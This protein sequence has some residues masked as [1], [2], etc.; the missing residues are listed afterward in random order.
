M[1]DK[2]QKAPKP[3]K[4]P[5][6]KAQ[7]SYKV[8]KEYRKLEKRDKLPGF[9][10]TI[11]I[12]VIFIGVFAGL[13]T[14]F[15]FELDFNPREHTEIDVSAP[16]KVLSA[17]MQNAFLSFFTTLKNVSSLA[18]SAVHT[19][20]SFNTLSDEPDVNVYL[21]NLKEVALTYIDTVSDPLYRLTL[22]ND[23]NK[24]LKALSNP[25]RI[26]IWEGYFIKGNF[27]KDYV[28]FRDLDKLYCDTLFPCWN[29]EDIHI[30]FVELELCHKYNG[31]LYKFCNH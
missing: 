18:D 29:A 21:L 7:E 15:D 14:Q 1:A 17:Q 5:K 24:Y 25:D 10:I 26:Y 20:F 12:F 11:I 13:Y 28:H 6:E 31:E 9:I 19:A 4:T 16:S 23:L 22:N 30:K 3:Q 8:H 27:H 2:K